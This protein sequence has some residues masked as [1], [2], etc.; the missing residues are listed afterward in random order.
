[1][2]KNKTA[3]ERARKI[4]LTQR[5]QAEANPHS[6]F[7]QEKLAE[8]EAWKL[9]VNEEASKGIEILSYPSFPP[10][11]YLA[12]YPQAADIYRPVGPPSQPRPLPAPSHPRRPPLSHSRPPTP[13][14]PPPQ[15][16]SGLPLSTTDEAIRSMRKTIDSLRI[17]LE[18]RGKEVEDY[19]RDLDA[20]RTKNSQSAD[21]KDKQISELQSALDAK[22]R[23]VQP[24][25]SADD[26]DKQIEELQKALDAKDQQVKSSRSID[27]KDRQIRGLQTDL[28]GKD[29][30]IRMLQS[31][32]QDKEKEISRLKGIPAKRD[33]PDLSD[34]L[35]L[36]FDDME[37]DNL[38]TS[39]SPVKPAVFTSPLKR[40]TPATSPQ[41]VF[42][43]LPHQLGLKIALS[44]PIEIGGVWL[45]AKKR[46]NSLLCW[47][48]SQQA[49]TP[50]QRLS[51]KWPAGISIYKQA[52]CYLLASEYLDDSLV[53]WVLGVAVAG[54]TKTQLI[55]PW[56]YEAGQSFGKSI[57]ATTNTI[58]MPIQGI[59]SEMK[60]GP[61]KNVRWT[62]E[63]G[64]CSMQTD[65][66]EC[67]SWVLANALALILDTEMPE[68]VDGF[69]LAIAC[70]LLSEVQK[71]SRTA[72][73]LAD[74]L[75]NN[76][77]Q[78]TQ[79]SQKKPPKGSRKR[80]PKRRQRPVL[81]RA[82]KGPVKP[83]DPDNS[84]GSSNDDDSVSTDDVHVLGPEV[85]YYRQ[86][87]N[88][89]E[90]F[91]CTIC[92]CFAGESQEALASHQEK[93]HEIPGL[94]CTWPGCYTLCK[95]EGDL[96][97]HVRRIHELQV[98]V[99]ETKGCYQRFDEWEEAE[100]HAE[101]LDHDV[102]EKFPSAPYNREDIEV[103]RTEIETFKGKKRMLQLK[104]RY[105]MVYQSATARRFF[106]NLGLMNQDTTTGV[107]YHR[108]LWRKYEASDTS[109]RP[110]WN[111]KLKNK[112]AY[113]K[114]SFGAAYYM[115]VLF[116]HQPRGWRLDKFITD[117]TLHWCEISHKCH[118]AYCLDVNALEYVL[119][120]Y[121]SDRASC[122]GS[123]RA[124]AGTCEAK[125]SLH[126]HDHCVQHLSADAAT[127]FVVRVGPYTGERRR[128]GDRPK[129]SGQ[130]DTRG[131]AP[132]GGW[133]CRYEMKRRCRRN[134]IAF[135]TKSNRDRHEALCHFSANW[136][137]W[138]KFSAK[139]PGYFC[140][141]CDEGFDEKEERNRHMER[142]HET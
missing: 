80:V 68:S 81:A 96:D 74:W 35:F 57:N 92:V 29:E 113:G 36:P 17:L 82:A 34:E 63:N 78:T 50:L 12:M 61:G 120:K 13:P 56:V 38:V 103:R 20:L 40:S 47:T 134:D 115:F 72:E 94:L 27:D 132:P 124:Q 93:D 100:A 30:H 39:P 79:A 52:M 76:V 99:C 18:S 122:A 10:G 3:S 102:N 109:A 121:N 41:S 59:L 129:K 95:G 136:K 108:T 117:W 75:F 89:D 114:E 105:Y 98:Y 49:M 85:N 46:K 48:T 55:S 5:K 77:A 44:M 19:K 66:Y 127:S 1:M 23:H 128:V 107:P 8:F 73:I 142:E 26:K 25:Q 88:L 28:V 87:P 4:V 141:V 83:K 125:K 131:G 2:A 9:Y 42:P 104:R 58:L 32:L 106:E 119:P 62:S 126:S 15:L 53:D 31:A 33:E 101:E 112:S 118:W 22:G 67:G 51:S 123:L 110:S 71:Q 6:R 24:S 135:P 37:V 60:D 97:L 16:P 137:E 84:Q 91:L 21:D 139:F 140:P 43:P 65:G 69:R 45:K 90:E 86:R 7:E 130:L 133:T 11:R 138:R 70:S 54:T 111:Y 116:F 64:K 14:P